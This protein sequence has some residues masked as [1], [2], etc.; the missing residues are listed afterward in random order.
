VLDDLGL[1]LERFFSRPG[2]G[3]LTESALT[4]FR[5]HPAIRIDSNNARLLELL[6]LPSPVLASAAARSL[7]RA[8]GMFGV[9]GRS[10]V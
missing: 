9:N 2:L 3:T 10:A 1:H 8:Q 5:P 7:S 4:L 6:P